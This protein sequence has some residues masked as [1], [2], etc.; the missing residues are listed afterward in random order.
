MSRKRNLTLFLVL[1]LVALV[2]AGSWI[3]GSSIMT[4]AEAAARTAPPT[5]SPILV[6]VEERV[7]TSDI[8][9]RGTARYGLPQSISIVPSA[10]KSSAGV[11][12]TLPARNAELDEGDV[13]LTASGRP[14]FVLQGDVPAYRDLVPGIAG[15]DVRQLEHALER[16]G[17]DPGPMDGAFDEQ[18]SAAVAD[19][20]T[21]A[22]W[23]PFGPTADQLANI[24]ALE[25]ELAI[26]VNSRSAASDAVAAA[27]LDVAAARANAESANT[28]ASADVG[29][30]TR[31]RDAVLA[32]PE[33]T[34]EERANANADLAAAQAAERAT[35]AAGEAAIQAALDAQKAAEREAR[36]AANSAGRIAADLDNAR[37]RTGVQAPADEIVF[38][39]AVPVRV[40]QINAVVG[41]AASGPVTT[42]TNYQLAIDSSL[43]LDEAQ[44]VKPDM[45]VAIDEPDLGIEATGVVARVA[46]TPGTFGVDG[47]HI[48]FE[49]FVDETP[50]TLEGFS[51]RLTIPVKSTGGAVTVVPISALSLA[52]DGTSR[53]QVDNNGSLEFVVVEPGLSADGFVEVTPVNGTLAPGQ[54]VVIGFEQ[55]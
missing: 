3:A 10:L 25:Q 43:A 32:D 38:M 21:S 33:S 30:K 44:L 53:V 34:P 45:P 17:F 18:T 31:A 40:E 1:A 11:I 49:V 27:A 15:D 16:L 26:A 42:V 55:Q 36:L 37:R 41:D 6:P 4:P 22:G 46:D 9:T 35:R 48:Y 13:M 39:P 47:F 50:V 8:V 14:V 20:Y 5:P 51:L 23:E 54:L 19:W 28:A 2:A 52:A 12:T 24:R 7:L 29:A